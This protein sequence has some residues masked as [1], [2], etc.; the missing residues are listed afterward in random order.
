MIS[1][2]FIVVGFVF[3]IKGADCLVD[4]AS[5]VA[6][7]LNI[8]DLVIG[9][10]VVAFGTSA[11]ELFVNIIASVKGNAGIAIGN[12]LGSTIANIFLVLGIAAL[13]YPLSITRETVRR[14]IPLSL[15][16][17]VLI[18]FLANEHM[19]DKS[20]HAVLSRGDAVFLLFF[21]IIFLYYSFRFAK[22]RDDI[23]EQISTKQYGLI[24]S[25][26]LVIIGLIGL[27]LGGKM[28]VDGAI[29]LA[30]LWG[31]SDSF[32]GLTIIAIGTCLPEL[33][34]SVVAAC[35]KNADI[36]IGNIVGS[37]IFNLFFVFGISALI[38]PLSFTSANN[39]DIGVMILANI[40]LI[41]A[42][43][44][45]RKRMIDRWEGV[46]FIILYGSYIGFLIMRG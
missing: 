10:T 17:A 41:L 27:G 3:L 14:E 21:F 42:M 25:S 22:R 36:A 40:L 16:A 43:F 35:K 11:P 31:V 18:G 26:A 1:F 2:L 44:M 34:T 7:R 46:I 29:R 24:T 38:R 8:S 4:G 6:R 33:A 32:I 12:L 37:N 39:I 30:L 19:I 13:I 28:I 9:M 15:V 5:S 20:A 45:G 23:A